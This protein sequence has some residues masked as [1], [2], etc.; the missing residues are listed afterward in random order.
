MQM[1]RYRVTSKDLDGMIGAYEYAANNPNE[2]KLWY[3]QAHP[4]WIIL[5][6][7]GLGVV[8]LCQ[9]GR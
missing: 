9:Y 8:N 2:I 7:E 5:S 4:E 1:S 3:L 6:I